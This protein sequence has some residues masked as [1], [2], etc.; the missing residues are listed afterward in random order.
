MTAAI[1]AALPLVFAAG[2]PVVWNFGQPALEGRAAPGA[3]VKVKLGA[4]IQESWRLYSLKRAEGGPIPTRIT[5]PEGQPFALA[6]AIEASEPIRLHDPVFDM[7]IE[8]YAG[9]AEFVLPVKVAAGARPGAATLKVA[10]RYQIC[11][12]KQCLPPRTVTL[13]LPVTVAAP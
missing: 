3:T 7:E 10:A 1:L 13:E 12:D 2:T 8:F 4:R 5:L 11:D 6:G 9:S